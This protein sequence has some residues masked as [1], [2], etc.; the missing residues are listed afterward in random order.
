MDGDSQEISVTGRDK[1]KILFFFNAFGTEETSVALER[2]KIGGN[3]HG[4]QNCCQ[5]VMSLC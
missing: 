3:D 4:S 1:N 2:G 5:G